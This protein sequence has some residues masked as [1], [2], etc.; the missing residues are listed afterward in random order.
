MANTVADLIANLTLDTSGFSTGVTTA[1]SSL[2][3]LTGALAGVA[4]AIGAA[5]AVDKLI[6]FGTTAVTMAGQMEQTNVAFTTLLGSATAAQTM[7]ADLKAFARETPF[8]FPG[9]Q[10]AAKR[11]LAFGFEASQIIPT[12]RTVGDTAS[13]LGS[14]AEG[15]NI[16]TRALGQMGAA[17]K[18]MT[19]D[20]NQLTNAGVR[21]WD[22]LAT[23]AGVSVEKMRELVQDGLVPS[24][25]AVDALLAGMNTLYGGGMQAQ[26]A[27]F[28]GQWSNFKESLLDIGLAVG[29][30]LIPTLNTLLNTAKP[31]FEAFAAWATTT[32]PAVS[33]A[34]Q[35]IVGG[36]TGL[37]SGLSAGNP[38]VDAL[39]TAAT[40]VWGAIKQWYENLQLL[41]PF[42][43]EF[44]SKI[45]GPLLISGINAVGAAFNDLKKI[46]EFL[47]PLFVDIATK[48]TEFLNWVGKLPGAK[49]MFG[50]LAET[51]ATLGT[52]S[53]QTAKDTDTL[54]KAVDDA[55]KTYKKMGPELPKITRD[56]KS[57][58]LEVKGAKENY[59][60]LSTEIINAQVKIVDQTAKVVLAKQATEA[61]NKA[62]EDG[63][64]QA[65]I[66][67]VTAS[68]NSLVTTSNGIP[69]VV[70]PAIAAMKLPTDQSTQSMKDLTAAYKTFGIDAPADL[71]LTADKYASMRDA[72]L[73]DPTAGEK[74][75]NTAVY[76]ALE[77]QAA[78][79]ASLGTKLPADQAKMM[80][81]LKTKLDE[82]GPSVQSAF[83]APFKAVANAVTQSV[84]NITDILTGQREGS[85]LGEL[86]NL[87]INVLEAFVNPFT[88]AINGLINGAIKSLM[89][90]LTGP[91]SI[92]SGLSKIGSSV[93]GIFGDGAGSAVSGAGG[94]ARGGI[95]GAGG[96]AGG[97]GS[98]IGGV[99]GMVNMISGIAGAAAGIIGLFHSPLAGDTGKTEENTRATK[100]ELLNLRADL[101]SQ[102]EHLFN[103]LDDWRTVSQEVLGN[104]YSRL[105]E[106]WASVNEIRDLQSV[107]MVPAVLSMRDTVDA[108]SH[109]SYSMGKEIVSAIKELGNKTL[110]VSVTNIGDFAGALRTQAVQGV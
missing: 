4:T 91:D 79:M 52:E 42:F 54:E 1:S 55:V 5:F 35:D 68:I 102:E 19:Q 49:I 63:T 62:W 70:L 58:G 56:T 33:T 29:N 94:A 18:V 87:G 8:D 108:M 104:V 23:G 69:N 10:D 84:G 103:K 61:W 28:L 81:D 40:A 82:K 51:F 83:E 50:D 27:T 93:S 86:K 66:D 45:G 59:K 16:I 21:A 15:I 109:E 72:I 95:G 32:G 89:G 22:I 105:G 76:K 41:M 17:G 14:G 13:A 107:E 38:Y 57:L 2:S 98:A 73:N 75:K 20:M 25:G 3:S 77:A 9:L 26:A 71:Q 78:Y 92:L 99:A 88:D 37:V 43:N 106:M 24:K 12:L 39:S 97:A 7:L 90:W 101:W 110:Q 67:A 31:A 6:D 100:E 47:G 64:A 48:V 11:M 80:D 34:L 44:M 46:L 96:A 30:A 74:A 53:K 60:N 85:I 36:I 65:E